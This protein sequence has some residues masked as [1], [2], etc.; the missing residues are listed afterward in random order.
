MRATNT[1][2]S[3]QLFKNPEKETKCTFKLICRKVTITTVDLNT[4]ETII[5]YKQA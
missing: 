3:Q 2:R 4:K 5:R 1:V